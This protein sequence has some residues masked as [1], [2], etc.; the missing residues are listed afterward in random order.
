MNCSS[1][2]QSFPTDFRLAGIAA[3][4]LTIHLG[5]C[6]L[7][8]WLLRWAGFHVPLLFDRPWAATT[9]GDFWG[10][11][12]N[13]AFVEMNRR[14]LLRPLYRRLGKQGSRFALF[15]LSGVVHELAL[16]LRPVAL[17]ISHDLFLAGR[18]GGHRGPLSYREPRVGLVLA[19]GSS[20]WLF[21]EPFRRALVVLLYR[22]LHELIARHTSD[23]YRSHALYAALAGHFIVLIASF[24][25]PARLGWKQ[26]VPKLTRFNQK[27][28]GA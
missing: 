10:R 4:L 19:A 28:F 13:L 18:S 6:D 16:S 1:T 11:R 25:A 12:W 5:I 24:Q 27:V 9:L 8:P 15:A 26:D 2:R 20:P 3:L 23:W 21:H 22:G 17:G 7:L 14:Y